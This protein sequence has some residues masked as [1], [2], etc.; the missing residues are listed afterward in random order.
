VTAGSAA[1]FGREGR[2]LTV[3]VSSSWRPPLGGQEAVLMV[4]ATFT[5]QK[6]ELAKASA[7]MEKLRAQEVRKATFDSN[8][9]KINE[10]RETYVD[11]AP[12][13]VAAHVLDIVVEVVGQHGARQRANSRNTGRFSFRGISADLTVP[14]L[15]T[16]QE[17]YGVLAELVNKLPRRNPRLIPNTT[18]EGRPAF[19]H[20]V[21]DHHEQKTR[22]VP[23]EEG[24][25]TRVRTY[26]EHYEVLTHS[27]Q[28]TEIDFGIEPRRL[29]EVQE[30]VAD[31]GTAI[32]VAIDEANARGHE[33][34]P[35]L[36]GVIASI[37]T[38]FRTAL[39]PLA[40]PTSSADAWMR[41]VTTGTSSS[42]ARAPCPT[43]GDAAPPTR[44]RSRSTRPRPPARRAASRAGCRRRC[45]APCRPCAS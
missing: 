10:V 7:W 40:F 11:Y 6:R 12:E 13:E 42:T 4:Q 8:K 15:R 38:V 29:T 19:A 27:T 21:Q 23:Y 3:F 5:R 44:G 22:S 17:A 18:V 26:E 34:D 39:P 30:L 28:V 32:Q 24:A 14:Q 37:R 41:S 33:R 9:Q 20:P 45:S 31:L 35:V 25:S 16:L 1:A 2:H 36:D 43:A